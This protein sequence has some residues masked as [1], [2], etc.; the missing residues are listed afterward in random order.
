[1]KPSEANI[2]EIN[3]DIDEVIEAVC[4][5][6]DVNHITFTLNI[7]DKNVVIEANKK[8]VD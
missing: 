1:M 5:E 7:N 8:E 2:M 6:G 3:K 4:Q